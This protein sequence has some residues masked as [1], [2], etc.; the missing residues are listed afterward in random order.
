MKLNKVHL[1]FLL[2]EVF[3]QGVSPWSLTLS[4]SVGFS[5]ITKYHRRGGLNHIY[6]L[7][8][9]RLRS[10]GPGCQQSQFLAR[11]HL[12][13]DGSLAEGCLCPVTS[14][15]SSLV[16][17][18]IGILILSDQGPPLYPHLIRIP[19]FLQKQPLWRLGL[20]H[21]N[22]GAGGHNSVHC[23]PPPPGSGLHCDLT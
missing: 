3:L 4:V 14:H 19:T 9:W 10:P 15:P 16:S 12:L 23:T 5:A 21:M 18:F 6:S 11:Y 1:T 8:F 13:I 2:Y 7:R 22:L 17:V 20:Q